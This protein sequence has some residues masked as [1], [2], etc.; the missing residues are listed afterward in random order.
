MEHTCILPHKS[1]KNQE[2]EETSLILKRIAAAG[3]WLTAA[4]NVESNYSAAAGATA[5]ALTNSIAAFT[6]RSSEMDSA[7]IMPLTC[8]ASM[9]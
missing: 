7:G 6:Q 4:I 1:G 5:L 3:A 2:R 8:S 9:L